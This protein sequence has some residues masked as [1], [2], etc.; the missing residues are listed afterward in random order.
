MNDYCLYLGHPET[1]DGQKSEGIK[2]YA[3]NEAVC[4]IASPGSGKSWAMAIPNLLTWPGPAF[5]LDIKGELY[6]ET[7]HIR[8]GNYGPVIR[9]N[10]DDPD[11][12]AFNPF[13][14][15]DRQNTKTFWGDCQFLANQMVIKT[16]SGDAFWENSARDLLTAILAATYLD[17]K[18][19]T[20]VSFELILDGLADRDTLGDLIN[21]LEQS[22]IKAVYRAGKTL[23]EL[24]RQEEESQSKLLHSFCIQAQSYLGSLTGAHIEQATER[25]DWQPEDLRKNNATVYLDLR[26]VDIEEFRSLIRMILAV[27]YRKLTEKLP[28]QD[29]APILFLLDEMPQLGYMKV[30][31]T[32]LDVG[33]GY[34]LKL[35]AFAQNKGQLEKAYDDAEGFLSKCAIRAYMNPSGADADNLA[36]D[37]SETFGKKQDLKTQQQNAIVEP[38]ELAGPKY[39]DK[40]IVIARG[41]EPVRLFKFFPK[42]HP[43]FKH[44]FTRE[45]S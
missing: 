18:R 7:A 17:E 20:P 29:D 44:L 3:G 38:W 19:K 43:S 35:W 39:Q 22:P 27:H 34:G 45:D 8:K 15:V 14:F 13:D 36:H 31:E 32:M 4:T 11:C 1:E 24:K 30:I 26:A 21:I 10:P 9:F 33:R 6:D 2:T 42:E 37:L 23:N 5:V 28:G 41:E 40:V 12:A 25:C 16:N